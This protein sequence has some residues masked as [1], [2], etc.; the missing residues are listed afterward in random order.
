MKALSIFVAMP[1][2]DMG[3]TA[4]WKRPADAERQYHRVKEAVSQRLNRQ[5]ELVFEKDRR[6][7]GSVHHTM[8]KAIYEADVLIADL[9]GANPN[10]AFELGTRYALRRSI[11][12]LTSQDDKV[13]FDLVGI[14][15]VRYANRP[16]EDF[17]QEVAEII[18]A[19]LATENLCDS[20][21]ISALDLQVVPRRDWERVAGIRVAAALNFAADPSVPSKQRLQA[22]AQA[23]EDDPFSLEARLALIRIHRER[24]DYTSGLEAI[25][26][27]MAYFSKTW[28]L[29]HQKGLILDKMEGPQHLL[30]AIAAYREALARHPDS[31][32]IHSCLGGS[33]RR[34][35]F[36]HQ[37]QER[38][39]LLLQSLDQYKHAVS[40]NRHDT[41][42]GLNTVRLLLLI[43]GHSARDDAEVLGHIQRM[44]HLCAFEVTDASLGQTSGR[45]WSLFDYADTCI[46]QEKLTDAL[47][48]Y[49]EAIDLIPTPKRKEILI[50]PQRTW[51]ELIEAEVLNAEMK[52]GAEEVLNLLK[53]HTGP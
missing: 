25:D 29:H 28:Q 40:L 30:D 15:L 34:L 42:A 2:T 12:I 4:K 7:G 36:R 24:Q 47:D 35:A 26:E 50:S 19:G 32:D 38:Q 17:I 39:D 8:Y 51:N 3:P 41:Y 6:Q 9:T 49:H 27:G 16:D 14:R 43:R 5:V 18:E 21:L 20:P 52:K 48:R 11:T 37:G 33:L 31:P 13:P 46:F 1:Y 23:T 44:F 10:V 45:W 53:N 22:V